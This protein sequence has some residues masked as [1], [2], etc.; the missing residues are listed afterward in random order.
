MRALRLLMVMSAVSAAG[1][2]FRAGAGHPPSA[3]ARDASGGAARRAGREA[4]GATT[5]S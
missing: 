2:G 1:G 4:R 5:L 3:T